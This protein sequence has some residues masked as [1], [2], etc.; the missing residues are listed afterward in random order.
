MCLDGLRDGEG[1]RFGEI[2]PPLLE[3]TALSLLSW[4]VGLGLK[5][6][7]VNVP[8]AGLPLLFQPGFDVGPDM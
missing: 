8:Y 4:L 1:L 5:G 6:G 2:S 3:A 7:R